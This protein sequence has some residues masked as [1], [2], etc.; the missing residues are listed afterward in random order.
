MLREQAKKMN[1][2]SLSSKDPDDTSV[3]LRIAKA[4][5]TIFFLFVSAWTPYSTVALL[6]N[7]GY[8]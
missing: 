1:V 3:E 5:I 4:A 8:G 6:S 7:F 2:K